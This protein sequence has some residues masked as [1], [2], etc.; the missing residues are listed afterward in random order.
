MTDHARVAIRELAPVL[1]RLRTQCG[2]NNR[3]HFFC[4]REQQQKLKGQPRPGSHVLIYWR[5]TAIVD[6][7]YIL[8]LPGHE[9]E[10][11]WIG[12][13]VHVPHP[14]NPGG[15]DSIGPIWNT[16]DELLQNEQVTKIEVLSP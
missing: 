10:D 4:T 14:D 12:G 3:E 1:G 5:S 16:L 2:F 11:V 9:P 13:V 8:T 15:K 7:G 6:R